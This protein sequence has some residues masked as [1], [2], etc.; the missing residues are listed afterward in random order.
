MTWNQAGHRWQR[1]AEFADEAQQ[2]GGDDGQPPTETERRDLARL[3]RLLSENVQLLHLRAGIGQ[4]V[5]AADAPD[6]STRRR[7]ALELTAAT[8]DVA[9]NYRPG[10][11][12]GTSAAAHNRA[13]EY[14]KQA[15]KEFQRAGMESVA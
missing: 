4:T 13:V 9:L 2:L 14:L 3:A 11:E 15:L 5:R 7:Q 8:I 1:A 6:F 10:T 12:S